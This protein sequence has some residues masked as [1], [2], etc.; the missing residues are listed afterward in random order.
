M[1]TRQEVRRAA[2]RK[3]MQIGKIKGGAAGKQ[4]IPLGG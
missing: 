3:F 2:R 1:R 4:P